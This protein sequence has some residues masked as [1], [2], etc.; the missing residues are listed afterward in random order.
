MSMVIVLGVRM[1]LQLC[2]ESVS[3]EEIRADVFRGQEAWCL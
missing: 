2:E 3:S 1:T